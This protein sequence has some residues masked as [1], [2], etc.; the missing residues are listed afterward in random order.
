M[1]FAVDFDLCPR[2]LFTF[3]I[4]M[5][6]TSLTGTA[7]SYRR[8]YRILSICWLQDVHVRMAVVPSSVG[9]VRR[10]ISLDLDVNANVPLT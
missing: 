6:I 1:I 4:S 10:E 8:E 2:A 5:G 3:L 7:H 9:V